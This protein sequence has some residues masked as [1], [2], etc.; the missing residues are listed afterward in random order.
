MKCE[1]NSCNTIEKNGKE[2]LGNLLNRLKIV[3]VGCTAVF[4]EGVTIVFNEESIINT[5][6]S[7]SCNLCVSC[8]PESIICKFLW[9][10]S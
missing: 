4:V 7:I 10:V 9:S 6:C 2:S 5:I 8:N 1:V 3:V